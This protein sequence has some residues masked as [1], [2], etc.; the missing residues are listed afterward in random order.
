MGLTSNNVVMV[1][2]VASVLLFGATIWVWPRLARRG[3]GPVLGRI[4]MLLVTQVSLFAALGLFANQS[5]G[6]YGSWSDL[7]GTET[8]P[9]VVVNHDAASSSTRVQVTDIRRV[10]VPG[11]SEPAAAGRIEKVTIKGPLSGL[12]S[13]AYV[14]LP[15]EYFQP[16]YARRDFPA[17]LVLTGYPG[18]TE[19]LINGLKY[20]QNAHKLVKDGRMQ[21][22]VLVMLRPTVAPPRDTEC[23]DVPQ[24]PQ[25]ETFF[26]KD[27][28]TA[29]AGHYRVG[30]HARNWGVIGNSTGGYCALKMA[31]RHPEAFSAAAG[32]SPS[33]KAPIDA[34]TGDLFGGSKQLE[35]EN[36]LMWRLDHKPAPPVSLLVS[37]SEHGEKNYKDTVKFIEK[38]KELNRRGEPIRISS[39]ILKTG[40][41]NFNTWKREVPAALE[42]LGGRLGDR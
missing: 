35:R 7:F 9:G 11:G 32:L 38:A 18:T 29:V 28:P 1:S 30:E 23:V 33:Y 24:G 6:F 34:T 27:V 40:G 12:A 10:N 8:T 42:W 5:F 4:G 16:E 17:V 19:A 13:P 20:P 15:P 21:P 31:M 2:V 22:M 41:H 3:V 26:T 37:S 36:N 39:I 25:T 14:Y